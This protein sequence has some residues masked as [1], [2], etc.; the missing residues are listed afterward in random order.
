MNKRGVRECRRISQMQ[1]ASIKIASAM[2]IK[3][4]SASGSW[5]GEIGSAFRESA[6]SNNTT[7]NPNERMMREL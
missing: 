4:M 1:I 3:T 7:T 5:S 2:G 6:E